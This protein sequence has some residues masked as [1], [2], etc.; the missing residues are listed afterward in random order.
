MLCG[1]DWRIGE[2]TKMSNRKVVDI[3]APTGT[4]LSNGGNGGEHNLHGRLSALEA[5]M[6]HMAT[7]AWVL[8]GV[9]G[10]M[11]SAALITLAIIKFFF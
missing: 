1:N 3:K 10:G 11:V 6:Q 7:K 8:G 2:A 4:P 9:V 5:H